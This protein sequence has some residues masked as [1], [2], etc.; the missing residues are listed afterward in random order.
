[1]IS[2]KDG[3]QA[4]RSKYRFLEIG[5]IE[6]DLLCDRVDERVDASLG[7]FRKAAFAQWATHSV[8]HLAQDAI[9]QVRLDCARVLREGG[10]RRR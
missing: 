4:V 5:R 7:S 2:G 1:M 8:S 10:F 9:R 3:F 6:T